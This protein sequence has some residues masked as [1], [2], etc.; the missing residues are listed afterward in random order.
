MPPKEVDITGNIKAIES[1]K[2]DLLTKTAALYDS[3]L[4]TT[5]Q[6]SERGDILADMAIAL[7]MLAGRLGIPCV[8]LDTTIANKLRR[9]VL[10]D[11]SLTRQD[12]AY[13]LKHI[14]K[15]EGLQ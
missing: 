15:R 3:L 12:G 13:L 2:V 11:A 6:L 9:I 4:K 8:T 14:E 7:Y 10:D 5:P 1:L